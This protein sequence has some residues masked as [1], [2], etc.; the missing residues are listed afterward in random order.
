MKFHYNQNANVWLF[1]HI[2]SIKHVNLCYSKS[3]GKKINSNRDC[4]DNYSVFSWWYHTNASCNTESNENGNAI[5][6]KI[7]N[8][9]N[10]FTVRIT[11]ITIIIVINQY[12]IFVALVVVTATIKLMQILK[13]IYIWRDDDWVRSLMLIF[14]TY[15]VSS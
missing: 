12:Q 6:K 2:V 1:V 10:R 3:V 13:V 9:N 14:F 11:I 15:T 8:N 4:N 5:P 7:I